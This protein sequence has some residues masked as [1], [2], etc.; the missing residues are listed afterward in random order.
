MDEHLAEAQEKDVGE[1]Q[2]YADRYIPADAPSSL[3]RGKG[4]SHNREDECRERHCK[5]CM[6][7]YLCE[8]H[9]G[10]TSHLLGVDELVQPSVRQGLYS[11]FPHIEVADT[12]VDDCVELLA[13][14]D[15]VVEVIPVVA[16]EIFLES[17]SAECAVPYGCLGGDLRH[18]LVIL[19][20][21]QGEAV[22]S[23]VPGAEGLHKNEFSGRN[24]VVYIPAGNHIAV[25]PYVLGFELSSLS[26]GVRYY[27]Q[28]EAQ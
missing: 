11:V 15:M 8:F 13:A 12:Q 28:V 24:L 25:P 21:F 2:R 7:F 23:V 19:Y 3:F 9:I 4:D 20:L 18:E 26:V 14:P 10:V 1:C 6:L 5:S 17:P 16:D 22:C 27:E